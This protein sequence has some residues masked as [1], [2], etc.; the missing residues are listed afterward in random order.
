MEQRSFFSRR[1]RTDRAIDGKNYFIPRTR[2]TTRTA[3]NYRKDWL[4]KLNLKV[5]E[6]LEET[7][8]VI[9]AFTTQDP[10]GN[11]R[12]DTYGLITAAAD[13]GLWGFGIPAVANGTG[14]NWVEKDGQIIPV[15]MTQEHFDMVKFFKR[16]YDE[17]LINQDF[18]TI[19]QE[20]GFELLNAEQGGMFFGNSDEITSRFTPLNE[21]TE[22]WKGTFR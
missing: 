21:Y 1:S 9:K 10:D 3:F 17:K 12:N 15:F 22:A 4:E 20:K 13:D 11:G 16:L 6:T 19:R 7:Y 5:P 2:V 18:A 8:D 14:N